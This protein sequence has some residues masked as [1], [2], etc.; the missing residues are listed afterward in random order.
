MQ[1]IIDK[2]AKRVLQNDWEPNNVLL[3]YSNNIVNVV[4]PKQNQIF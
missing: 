2:G 1:L 4:A 3:K